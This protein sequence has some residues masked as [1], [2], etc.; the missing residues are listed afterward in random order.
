MSR[1]VEAAKIL[2]KGHYPETAEEVSREVAER[3]E[4]DPESIIHVALAMSLEEEPWWD[5]PSPSIRSAKQLGCDVMLLPS[6]ESLLAD[7]ETALG[8]PLAD[9]DDARKEALFTQRAQI[10]S[11]LTGEPL[12]PQNP[13]ESL[14]AKLQGMISGDF[15][16]PQEDE[17]IDVF[18]MPE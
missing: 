16:P 14:I 18:G 13:M 7:V 9:T 12:P 17:A 11:E 6:L 3:W 8:K 15:V 1:Y 4:Q 5:D 2:L 10:I